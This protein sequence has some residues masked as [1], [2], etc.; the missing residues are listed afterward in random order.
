MNI[1]GKFPH[2]WYVVVVD[3]QVPPPPHSAVRPPT[4]PTRGAVLHARLGRYA[5]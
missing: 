3:C 2:N 5:G 1:M 4:P